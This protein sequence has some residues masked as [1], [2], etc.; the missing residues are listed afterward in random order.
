MS[1][2]KRGTSFQ[3]RLPGEQARTFATRAAAERYE[4]HRR[5]ARQLGDLHDEEPVTVS[6]MLD[7][8]LHR[9]QV[10]A[11]PAP[12]TV[13]R[14]R[15]ACLFWQHEFGETPLP[16]LLFV[17]VEDA[18][19]ARAAEH[20]NS[21]KKELEWLKRGLRDAQRRKQRFD[22]ALLLLDPIQV[23]ARE[24]VA[25]D[26]DELDRLGSW[27]PEQLA[28]LPEIV[29]SV[30]LR[31]GEALTLTDDR[32]DLKTGHLFIPASLCKERRDK[33]VELA[34]FERDLLA[35]QLLVRT[36]GTAVVF[37]RAGGRRYRPG[38]WE[39]GDFYA[40]VWHPARQAAA[41][42]WRADNRLP[43][44]QP[45]RFDGLV[46]H[47]LR[48]TAISLMAA[49]GMRP[50]LI[51]ARVGHKDGGRLILAR[52]RHL[53]PDELATHLAGYD[54]FIRERRERKAAQA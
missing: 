23:S 5:L 16:R 11:G 3:V 46:P 48:H 31:I 12:G 20:P 27:F 41:N 21:A 38:P 6:E 29:G 47:D 43:A 33:L 42:E 9:W 50:E 26:V 14:A 37:P 35:E 10:T 17:E 45:T 40:R 51:A 39:K 30:G 19:V 22:L 53:F 54:G 18:I 28:L 24:G 15:E 32:V 8:Y 13:K 34:P 1:I 52:Y 49:G 36:P 7:G 25:L 4:L 2:R 44:W